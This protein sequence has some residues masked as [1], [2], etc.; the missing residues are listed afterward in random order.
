MVVYNY[1]YLESSQSDDRCRWDAFPTQ[2]LCDLLV[3]ISYCLRSHRRN[4]HMIELDC[5]LVCILYTSL[6]P[7]AKVFVRQCPADVFL[8]WSLSQNGYRRIFS[9]SDRPC[10]KREPVYRVPHPTA[11]RGTAAQSIK[12]PRTVRTQVTKWLAQRSAYLRN[13]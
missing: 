2:T 11:V 5:I 1:A 8:F 12:Q 3:V 9:L 10:V 7:E 6:G 13:C 4:I